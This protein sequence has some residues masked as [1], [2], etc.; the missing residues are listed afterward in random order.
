MWKFIEELENDPDIYVLLTKATDV[1]D[2]LMMNLCTTNCL[3]S[4]NLANI[5]LYN[6]E[7]A[8]KHEEIQNS[9]TF[10]NTKYQTSLIYGTKICLVSTTVYNEL[11]TYIKLIRP[12]IIDDES[13]SSKLRYIFAT[14]TKSSDRAFLDQMK[15]SLVTQCL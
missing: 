7:Y 11:K 1:R 12:I 15:H 3:R 6:F 9:H 2:Y 13:K 14:S 8:E 4:S 5:T 10:R